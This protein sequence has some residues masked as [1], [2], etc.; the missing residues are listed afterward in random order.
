MQIVIMNI[1]LLISNGQLVKFLRIYSSN[2]IITV[3]VYTGDHFVINLGF[4][5]T[6][7]QEAHVM[8]EIKQIY[9][10]KP[11]KIGFQT[12]MLYFLSILCAGCDTNICM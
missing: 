1:M 9:H 5:K 3:E 2:V 6:S 11:T 12:C 8:V 7:E 10:L 4:W